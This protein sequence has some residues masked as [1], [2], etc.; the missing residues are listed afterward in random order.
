MTLSR[1][2]LLALVPGFMLSAVARAA[3][4]YEVTRTEAEWKALLTPNQFEVLR[5]AG[6]ERPYSSPLDK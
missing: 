5:K 6:T 1:R 3:K 2:L 4:A